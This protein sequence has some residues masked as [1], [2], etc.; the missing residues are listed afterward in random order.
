MKNN[1][2]SMEQ[3]Q[4]EYREGTKEEGLS[5]GK[6]AL[7]TLMAIGPCILLFFYGTGMWSVEVVEGSAIL[8]T[9]DNF[10]TTAAVAVGFFHIII[11]N[12]FL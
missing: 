4:R 2:K 12:A 3:K 11:I 7:L 8:D 9:A 6:K 1:H 5:D 10:A